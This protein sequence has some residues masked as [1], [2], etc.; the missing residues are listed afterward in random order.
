MRKPRARKRSEGAPKAR[1][2][3]AVSRDTS[4]RETREALLAAALSLFAEQGLDA[5]S[6]DAIC[7]RAG[8]TRGAFYVHFP[9]RD[10]L[11]VA[12]M[13]RVGE[14]FLASVFAQARAEHAPAEAGAPTSLLAQVSD[15]FLAAI[16]AGTYPLMPKPNART[17]GSK[18]A[19]L[20]EPRL[21]LH[22]LLEACGRS[23]VVR[24]RYKMLV[25]ASV[26]HVAHLARIDQ[27][28]GS[29]RR[30]LDPQ[31][32]GTMILATVIGAQTMAELGVPIDSAA[33]ARTV[34]AMLPDD[35]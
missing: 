21:R 31:Q 33:L 6:L 32:V 26:A 28:R 16:L 2:A 3:L 23:A 9:D 5:P 22:Q 30:A 1:G 18:S 17:K 11:L 20:R 15:R 8:Y 29:V 14:A 10:A 19:T 34:L 25:E 35:T 12:V 7:D 27:G 4:K 24:E 13:D